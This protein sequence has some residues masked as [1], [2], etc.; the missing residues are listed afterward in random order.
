MLS[1][2]E[3]KELLN[4]KGKKYTNSEIEQ[5]R[6]FLWDLAKIEVNNLEKSDADENSNIDEQGK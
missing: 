5:I 3:C 1:I 2:D 6:D 4:G